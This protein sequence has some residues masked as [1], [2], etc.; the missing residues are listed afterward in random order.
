MNLA[1]PQAENTESFYN[2]LV[3]TEG[4]EPVEVVGANGDYFV[5]AEGYL[6]D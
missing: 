5:D 3:S 6:I 2:Q 1:E 4:L